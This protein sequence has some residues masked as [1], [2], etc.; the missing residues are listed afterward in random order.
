ML[1]LTPLV[2][3]LAPVAPSTDAH[4]QHVCD[5]VQI[6]PLQLLSDDD[7]VPWKILDINPL[8]P[9]YAHGPL[10]AN[11]Q[12]PTFLDTLDFQTQK[13]TFGSS[14]PSWLCMVQMIFSFVVVFP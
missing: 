7:I 2:L 5:Q 8:A 3:L 9:T 10:P 1:I 13:S 14:L 4:F 11:F 6:E 12:I